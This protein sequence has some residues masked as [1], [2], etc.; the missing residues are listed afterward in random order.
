[1]LDTNPD[2]FD[3]Q[4]RTR[5]YEIWERAGRPDGHDDHFWHLA[6]KACLEELNVEPTLRDK[7][8]SY[9]YSAIKGLKYREA[10][11]SYEFYQLEQRLTLGALGERPEVLWYYTTGD[12]MIRILSGGE[13]WTTQAQCLND[14]LEIRHGLSLLRD[15]LSLRKCSSEQTAFHDYLMDKLSGT[16]RFYANC[17]V[18]CFSE[19]PNDLSQWRGYSGGENGFSLGFDSESLTEKGKYTQR[20]R[21]VKVAYDDG[22]NRI[23]CRHIIDMLFMMFRR[24]LEPRSAAQYP[25]DIWIDALYSM[26][27]GL[28]LHWLASMKHP[29]FG[30]EAEWRLILDIRGDTDFK[31]LQKSTMMTR[32]LPIHFPKIDADNRLVPVK[33]VFV[34]PSR[35]PDTSARSVQSLL[36]HHRYTEEK[37]GWPVKVSISGIPFQVP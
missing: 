3:E 26:F 19:K 4:V 9:D 16:P 36:L 37:L 27:D 15:V 33:E 32:H 10:N 8:S 31:Y 25:P 6:R 12:T 30:D 35:H 7:L 13:I 2:E 5:A 17:F 1:M 34:G 11:L 20:P 21:L 29:A 24:G 28:A 23:K 18:A 14:S 22:E